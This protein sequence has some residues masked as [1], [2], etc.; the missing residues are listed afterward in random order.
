M[1]LE[2][3]PEKATWDRKELA[4]DGFIVHALEKHTYGFIL[5]LRET[6][7]TR[8]LHDSYT[9]MFHYKMDSHIYRFFLPIRQY[10]MEVLELILSMK[11]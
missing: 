3:V 4:W 1:S 11:G 5:T 9:I 8:L 2:L 10:K 7:V 6:N